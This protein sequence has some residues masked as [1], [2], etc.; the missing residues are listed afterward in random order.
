M[1]IFW[2]DAGL[3]VVGEEVNV[4]EGV[5]KIFVGLWVWLFG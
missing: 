2:P 5:K 3:F 1:I 4:R